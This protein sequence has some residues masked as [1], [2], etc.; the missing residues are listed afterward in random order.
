M[1]D[2]IF[3]SYARED[4]AW[5]ARFESELARLPGNLQ[6]R[7]WTDQ[8]IEPGAKWNDRIESA[9][10]SARVAVLFVSRA[11]VSSE[12][13]AKSELPALL[14]A[15]SRGQ[16][17]LLWAL[18]ETCAL[19]GTG[20]VE[21]QA[22]LPVDQPLAEVADAT[23][24]ELLRQLADRV[25]SALGS[26][27]VK[28]RDPL[29][30][31]V[32]AFTLADAAAAE[33]LR[34]SGVESRTVA[35]LL[36]Q[37]RSEHNSFSYKTKTT[38]S[39]VSIAPD[40]PYRAAVRA[41]GPVE[42]L[43]YWWVPFAVTPLALDLRIVNNT[44]KTVLIR[45]AVFEVA[46]ST[47]DLEPLLLIKEDRLG[48]NVGHFWLFNEGWGTV[49]EARV[50]ARFSDEAAREPGPPFPYEIPLPHIEDSHNVDLS[51]ALGRAGVDWQALERLAPR[52]ISGTEVEI[53]GPDGE[54]IVI[55]EVEHQARRRAAFGPFPSGVAFVDG[56]LAYAWLDESGRHEHTLRFSTPVVLYD[57]GR[58]GRPMPPSAA[59]GVELEV[60]GRDYVRSVP[61]SHSL[62]PSEA[63]RFLIV[64]NV[65]RSSLHR[66]RLRLLLTGDAEL[67]S[68]EIRLEAVVP[69]SWQDL[70]GARRP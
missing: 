37:E 68:D 10:M 16:L 40:F 2:G 49:I 61:L 21:R 48:R 34:N 17:T 4:A 22:A 47:P 50:R 60:S 38:A 53:E 3:I 1:R 19:D 30:L 25:K 36:A 58:V 69:R 20:L 24:T 23:A 64:I 31:T 52:S 70:P 46:E 13:I 29:E 42:P 14:Q 44:S 7:I 32:S 54:P 55:D 41:G 26:T 15:A 45:E 18:L 11:F 63:D 6:N 57:S 39:G 5:R 27:P 28:L 8:Q 62:A 43:A 35:A 9:L 12:F 51:D 56:E 65:E 59:Y 33:L 67:A 66:L